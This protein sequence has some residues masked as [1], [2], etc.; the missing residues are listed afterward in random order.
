MNSVESAS[1]HNELNP[2]RLVACAREQAGLEDFGADE[3]LDAL[4]KFLGFAV[5][6]GGLTDFGRMVIEADTIRFL[7]NRLRF[8]HDLL[9]H[10]E[11]LDEDVSDP[12]IVTGLPR[13]GTS[14][15]QRMMSAHPSVQR[16]VV[17]RLLNPAPMG[18]GDVPDP[19][20]AAAQAAEA[21]LDNFPD[22][23]AAHPTRALEVDEDALLQ[24]L[25]FDTIIMT[26]RV[27]MPSYLSWINARPAGPRYDF[28]KKMLQYLQW[29]DGGAQGRP[30]VLKTPVHVGH[31]DTVAAT[32][33][34]A[35]IVHC[36]R[37]PATVI[38]SFAKAV[39]ASRR[40]CS[41][42]VN[43][44]ELGSEQLAMWSRAAET[45]LEQR[46]QLGDQLNVVDLPYDLIRSDAH[47]AITRV[48]RAAGRD[49]SSAARA[50]VDSWVSENPQHRFGK[51]SYVLEDYQ[52]TAEQI[53]SA[54]TPYLNRFGNLI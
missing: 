39:A 49:Y 28:E 12:I 35:T 32:F 47:E 36:H 24:E 14:K 8:Q 22:F 18:G 53:R 54:F 9:Q 26:F 21:M 20:V 51:H 40:I 1:F 30:W 5:E 42:H 25:T 48:Y 3:F 6:E 13:T 7:V 50:H 4:H 27:R 17:W 16:L 34:T 2:D 31:L 52:L 10:P 33:P 11:I 46:E 23:Q 15:L 37:D 45:N 29:Q 44:A 43:A 41:D 19:R 38:P